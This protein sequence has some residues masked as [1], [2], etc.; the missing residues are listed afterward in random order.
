MEELLFI[1]RVSQGFSTWLLL[2]IGLVKICSE[3]GYGIKEKIMSFVP[4]LSWVILAKIVDTSFWKLLLS[5]LGLAFLAMV[6]TVLS[7][8]IFDSVIIITIVALLTAPLPTWYL[9]SKIAEEGGHDSPNLL[10]ILV[11]FPI[12]GI[13]A[14][15][16]II[17]KG[18]W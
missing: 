5:V 13:F 7:A 18:E 11:A 17:W 1:S 16:Y 12:I 4:L 3:R 9:W 10:G 2:G 15:F 14:L 8:I 6:L